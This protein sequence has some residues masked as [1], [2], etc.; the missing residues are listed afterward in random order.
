VHMRLRSVPTPILLALAVALGAAACGDDSGE[1]AL[2]TTTTV[3]PAP[4]TTAGPA[5]TGPSTTDPPAPGPPATTRPPSTAPEPLGPRSTLRIDGVGPVRTG[6]TL[7]QAR[8]A[9]GIPMN[10]VDGG[11]C[12]TLRPADAGIPVS[13]VAEGGDRVN[14][15]EV[16]EGPIRTVSGIGIGSTEAEVMAAY[17]NQLEVRPGAPGAHWVI[18]RPTGRAA[19]M[20]SLNFAI[21]ESGK[22]AQM[23]AGLKRYTEAD[24]NCA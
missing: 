14:L 8:E 21:D 12:R 24:E 6:M 11:A 1:S 15:I 7:D 22:V 17:P 10:A 19:T 2:D 3:A 5:A 18:Y 16:T 23:R 13:I 4:S 20:H 9:A